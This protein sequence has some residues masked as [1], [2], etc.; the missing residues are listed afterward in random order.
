MFFGDILA[1]FK[2]CVQSRNTQSEQIFFAAFFC[3]QSYLLCARYS[4]LGSLVLPALICILVNVDSLYAL[5]NFLLPASL[6]AISLISVLDLL[7][8]H[9]NDLVSIGPA[10]P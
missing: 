4:F 1:I 7:P 8:W 5:P 3:A 10:Q 9:L 6:N 2:Y